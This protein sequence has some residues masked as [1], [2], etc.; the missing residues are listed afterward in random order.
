VAIRILPSQLIDQIAAGEVVER[1]ASVVKELVENS[2]DAG[3]RSIVVE[4]EAGGAKLIRVTDD[5][6]GIPP[7][8]LALAMSRHATSKIASLDD[9]EA[10]VTLGFRGEALPSIGSVA[11]VIVTSR[12]PGAEHAWSLGCDG[13]E[14]GEVRPAAHPFGTCIEVRDLFFNTP[15]RRKF[16]RSDKT[17][18]GH[19]DA[20]VKN[21]ALA[22]FD[23]RFSL[24]SNQRTLFRVEAAADRRAQEA[25]I[26][27]L[28]GT[29]FL[30]NAR[31]FE[32]AI[33]GLA[34]RGWLAA[35]AFS[36]S[37]PDL[38]F[39]FVNG[40]F[41][42]D[43]LLRHA[44]RLGY[45]D[46]LFGSRQP[47]FVAFLTLD[48]RRVDV[49]AH[50]AKL[51]IRFRDSRLVHDFVFRTVEAAL[52][53]TLEGAPG[54]AGPPVP[55]DAF[56]AI[57]QAGLRDAPGAT[58]HA[59]PADAF[60]LSAQPA[61]PAQDGAPQ[62]VYQRSFV[63]P[64][65]GVRDY[66]PLYERLHAPVAPLP[67]EAADDAAVPPL[68]YALAQL[69]G[70][71][72][73]AENRHGLIIVDMHAAHERITYERLKAALGDSKLKSQ[74]LLVPVALEV[75]PREADLAEEFAADLE[76][77]GFAVVRRGPQQIAVQG[78]PLL[79]DGTDAAPLLRDLLSDLAE[80]QGAGRIEAMVNELLATMAC[81]AAVRA[82]RRLTVAE[83]NALLREMERTER[84]EAC[85]HGRPTWT[86]V[87]LADLDRLFLRGQ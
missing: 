72:V 51:E 65:A 22:R 83:M 27:E 80:N 25:R 21:L 56:G 77:L 34:L 61:L 7:G 71:Y 14:L 36:R 50:P 42:R 69:A 66:L 73:L 45:Q 53:S 86:Q 75:T 5:G 16:Q 31:Y 12:S 64:S 39:T 18:A 13:G 44:V 62:P 19:V 47:A 37:Q 46:V 4:I 6:H 8:E 70:V 24:A 76:G 3:A 79:L 17:E 52:A 57:A 15:A 32:R 1:P 58:A 74:S 2:L 41:V 84:S 38:Q 49:N 11:R 10:L 29:E 23:V 67:A 68:G 40:R 85:N 87:S 35:P 55:G 20:V 59:R 78:I 54:A 33:E 9:L 82:N 30:A 81:H 63:L 43:K 48:P 26:A 60:G 28:C